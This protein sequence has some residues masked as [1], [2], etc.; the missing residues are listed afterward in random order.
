MSSFFGYGGNIFDNGDNTR[1]EGEEKKPSNY[2]N[3]F[4]D[5]DE[6]DYATDTGRSIIDGYTD[7]FK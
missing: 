4:D 7:F 3:L 2:F 6:D 1:D 5:D